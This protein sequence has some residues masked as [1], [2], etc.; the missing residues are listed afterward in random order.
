MNKICEMA[1]V[2]Q[3]AI[4]LDDESS[5]ASQETVSRLTQ[6]N[7]TLRE[8]LQM[9]YVNSPRPDTQDSEVQT[10]AQNTQEEADSDNDE[11]EGNENEMIGMD[12]SYTSTDN[13]F[14]NPMQRSVIEVFPNSKNKTDT[15]NADQDENANS[16]TASSDIDTDNSSVISAK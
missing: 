12:D 10:E 11:E 13:S 8:L 1:A 6:E 5:Q 15:D 3:Q 4:Q 14:D 9:A 7:K 16:S 2:M